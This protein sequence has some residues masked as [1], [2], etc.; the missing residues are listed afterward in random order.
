MRLTCAQAAMLV[1]LDA[2]ESLPKSQ[3]SKS[4]LAPLQHASVVRLE[5][6]GSSYVV[7][8]IPG[9]LAELAAHRWGIRDLE[10]YAQTSPENRSRSLMLDVAGDSKALPNRP[11]DGVFVRSFGN[12]FIADKPLNSSPPGTAVLI[13]LSEFPKLR[14]AASCLVAVENV[15]CLWQFEKAAR[16]FPELTGLDYAVVLRWHWGEAWRQWLGKW[17]GQLLYIPDYDPAGLKIYVTEVLPHCSNSRLLIPRNFE[18]IL[19]DRGDRTLYLKHEKYLPALRERPELAD[20]CRVLKK[21]R[22]AL[23]QESLLI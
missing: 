13:T 19:A 6:S 9:K 11:I 23:E 8:G 4:L 3:L 16:H 2:G 10:R 5:K 22:K 21:T 20:I 18:S 1:K 7:R 12:C 15:E 14:V 17:K